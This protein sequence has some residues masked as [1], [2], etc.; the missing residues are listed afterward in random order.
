M[1][2]IIETGGKQ[3]KVSEGDVIFVEKLVAEEGAAVKFDKVL[4]VGGENTVIGQ[5]RPDKPKS[6]ERI[7]PKVR[8]KAA[9]TLLCDGGDHISKVFSILGNE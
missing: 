4:V 3:Y 1:Y 6:T 5:P 7:D 8:V 9:L 2:A